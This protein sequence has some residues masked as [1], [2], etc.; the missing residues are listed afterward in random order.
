MRIRKTWLIAAAV[1]VVAAASA[2]IAWLVLSGKPNHA[3][4]LLL[5]PNSVYEGKKPQPFGSFYKRYQPGADPAVARLRLY[6]AGPTLGPL[7]AYVRH[8]PNADDRGVVVYAPAG[9]PD[10]TVVVIATL[11][12]S[13]KLDAGGRDMLN[14]MRT[15]ARRTTIA[16]HQ[17][18]FLTPDHLLIAAG[19]GTV[20]DLSRLYSL[21][22][23][24]SIRSI[25]ERL[26][27]LR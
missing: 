13:G 27:V 5:Q 10:Q 24:P 20:V 2:L 21:P 4:T 25:A 1:V 12:T 8:E 11:G 14:R 7:V 16:G 6:W 17:A 19:N 23:L 22:G 15:E 26:T 9:K 3:S 18:G